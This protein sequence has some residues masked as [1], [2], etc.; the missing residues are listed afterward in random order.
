MAESDQVPHHRVR[1][2]E[3][4]DRHAVVALDVA[5][6]IDQHDRHVSGPAAERGGGIHVGSH[7]DEA[8]DP[9]AHRS[10]DGDQLFQVGVGARDQQVEPFAA[11]GHVETADHA[12]EELPV[13]VR[14]QH[15][16]RVGAAR[17]Q[18]AGDAVGPVV[19]LG[20]DVTNGAF[21]FRA[22]E[23][24]VVEHPRH[25]RDRDARFARYV[26]DRSHTKLPTFEPLEV[27]GGDE[28][29]PRVQLEAAGAV[30]PTRQ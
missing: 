6:R 4:G 3:V 22:H 19:E 14:Q 18:A 1:A 28:S 24:A 15:T 30:L 26:L 7:D 16:E 20:G 23:T 9:P 21:G 12:R 27:G 29:A 10:H 25:G 17:D 2:L 11:G 5:A 8:V 13:Q